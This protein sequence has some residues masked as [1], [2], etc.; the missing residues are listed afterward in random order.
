MVWPKC[1][2]D[3]CCFYTIV[4]LASGSIV[5]YVILEDSSMKA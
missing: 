3:A 1:I 2:S 5:L 4:L